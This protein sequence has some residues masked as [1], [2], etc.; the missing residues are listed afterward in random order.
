MLRLLLPL[1]WLP[2]LRECSGF[3]GLQY[4]RQSESPSLPPFSPDPSP[5][6]FLSPPSPPPND[7]CEVYP[8]G[9]CASCVGYGCDECCERIC[10][11]TA[12]PPRAPPSAT[13]TQ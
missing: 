11:S 13:A 1:L 10:V 8:E 3:G 12:P 2:W 6:P 4:M 9:N 5:P 7:C